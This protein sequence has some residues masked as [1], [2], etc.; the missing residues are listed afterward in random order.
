MMSI[1]QS[2]APPSNLSPFALWEDSRLDQVCFDLL[3]DCRIVCTVDGQARQL[4]WV[5]DLRPRAYSLPAPRRRAS[6]TSNQLLARALLFE[7]FFVGRVIQLE[8]LHL[9]L[10][11]FELRGTRRRVVLWLCYQVRLTADLKDDD[12]ASGVRCKHA[13]VKGCDPEIIC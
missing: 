5:N 2:I 4:A 12:I 1:V 11:L 3:K 8:A 13:E 7:G 9:S 6:V 10:Q